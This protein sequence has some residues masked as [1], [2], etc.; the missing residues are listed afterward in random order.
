[1]NP[2]RNVS[3]AQQELKAVSGSVARLQ[4]FFATFQ[5]TMEQFDV[6][7][8]GGVAPTVHD[9]NGKADKKKGGDHAPRVI[10]D[11]SRVPDSV[12]SGV[13]MIMEDLRT[14]VMPKQVK[15]EYLRRGWPYVGKTPLADLIR[16]TMTDMVASER[17]NK[18]SFGY[19]LVQKNLSTGSATLKVDSG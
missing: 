4:E 8:G 17:A 7:R 9:S 10:L 3:E 12:A 15:A 18:G 6:L 11:P 14:P 19:S 5:K 16:T 13:R 1:M 2:I